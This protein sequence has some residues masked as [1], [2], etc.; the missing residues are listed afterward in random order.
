M[1][2][3]AIP[4]AVHR[5]FDTALEPSP[6]PNEYLVNVL[7]SLESPRMHRA[8]LESSCRLKRSSLAVCRHMYCEP[9]LQILVVLKKRMELYVTWALRVHDFSVQNILHV[10]LDEEI[11]FNQPVFGRTRQDIP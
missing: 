4:D 3:D 5:S 1:R 7:W 2:A 10:E 6:T 11:L 9:I 8:R